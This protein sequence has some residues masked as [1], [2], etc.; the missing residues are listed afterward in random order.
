[1]MPYEAEQ[2]EQKKYTVEEM[3]D[4]L[5][6]EVSTG[7]ELLQVLSE[8]GFSLESSDSPME[9]EEDEAFGM[10]PE[11]PDKA[12][13]EGMDE[14]MEEGA[15][16]LDDVMEKAPIPVSVTEKPRFDLVAARFRAADKAMSKDK[17][18][19]RKRGGA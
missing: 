7:E 14:G 13:K 15:D 16:L 4:Y 3:A 11:D 2:G 18:K 12:M 5:A 8:H 1:M 17:S 19:G 10:E 9:M 6:R